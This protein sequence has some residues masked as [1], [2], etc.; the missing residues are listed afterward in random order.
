[1]FKYISLPVLLNLLIL[2]SAMS[3]SASPL[4]SMQAAEKCDTCHTKPDRADPKWVEGNYKTS[5][6]KCRLACGVCHV[7]PSGGML[8]NDSGFIYGTKILPWNSEMPDDVKAGLDAIKSN[9][10]LTFGGDFRFLFFMREGNRTNPIFFPMQTDIY[11]NA[12]VGKHIAFLAQFGMERGGNS[13]VRE[14]IGML[15][16]LPYNSYFKVG[17]FVPPYGHRLEDHTAFIRDKIGLNHSK[18]EAY[19]SGYEIGAEPVLMYARFSQFNSD[20]TP[21][22]GSVLKAPTG[23]SGEAGWRGLWLHLGGSY[24]TIYDFE[25]SAAAIT[26]R[27]AYGVFGA[28]R[29]KWFPYLERLT[30][31]FEYDFRR[32]SIR[33]NISNSD[34]NA[35]ITYNEL[36]YRVGNGV[37]IKLRYE[38][39][40]P[41]KGASDNIERKRYVMGVDMYPYPFT[42]LNIQYRLNREEPESDNNEV[43]LLTHIWF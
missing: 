17:K 4:F 14:A 2:S 40:E 25:T 16:D 28:L 32:D 26:D 38:S 34:A 27:R 12:N 13:A 6:R 11:A 30:Y 31:L 24:L 18:P 3:S 9:R 23:I 42:E 20:I 5:E 1:M 33:G 15:K 29:L 8:R 21:Q 35:R 41:D 36:D 37:N 10:F 19:V 7:N 43:F 39:Y 22:S